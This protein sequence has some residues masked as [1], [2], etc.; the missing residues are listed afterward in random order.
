MKIFSVGVVSKFV[1]IVDISEQVFFVGVVSKCMKIVIVSKCIDYKILIS[2]V[3][4]CL[5]T[6]TTEEL[7]DAYDK[8]TFRFENEKHF[9]VNDKVFLFV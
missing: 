9:C 7:F 8:G 6:R 2:K 5:R 1:T 3:E 4:R